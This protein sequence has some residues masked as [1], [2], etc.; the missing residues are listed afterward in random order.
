L[1]KQVRLDASATLVTLDKLVRL[2]TPGTLARLAKPERLDRVVRLEPRVPPDR[3]VRLD[4][5][6]PPVPLVLPARLA[7]PDIPAHRL[8]SPSPPRMTTTTTNTPTF[9]LLREAVVVV[10]NH[11]NKGV[12]VDNRLNRVVVVDNRL[13]K[14]VVDNQA[15]NLSNLNQS[16]SPSLRHVS[17]HLSHDSPS[18][19]RNLNHNS[20]HPRLR[21]SPHSSP[22]SLRSSLVTMTR[23]KT[24]TRKRKRSTKTMTNTTASRGLPEFPERKDTRVTSATLGFQVSKERWDSKGPQDFQDY[25]GSLEVKESLDT[26]VRTADWA[27]RAS[28][29]T[30][31]MLESPANPDTLVLPAI[32]DTFLSRKATRAMRDTLDSV[33]TQE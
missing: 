29:D 12:V 4:L 18:L 17:P 9:S 1:E 20:L 32:P 22:S 6:A 27:K 16:P 3:P 21:S 11:L 19:N 33:D 24:T 31:A 26:R 13:S 30:K 28:L 15:D 10:D 23:R 25:P 5:L 8:S 2:A 7:S 14:E